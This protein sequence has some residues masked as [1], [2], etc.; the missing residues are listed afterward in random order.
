M[1]SLRFSTARAAT[2]FADFGTGLISSLL[3]PRRA[4]AVGK[5]RVVPRRD[6]FATAMCCGR[7]RSLRRQRNAAI[8][9]PT[10]TV[11]RCA[12]APP[13]LRRKLL[14]PFSDNEGRSAPVTRA[15]LPTLSRS[16]AR[17]IA[18][19]ADSLRTLS[20]VA[21]FAHLPTRGFERRLRRVCQPAVER[22]GFSQG[23]SLFT[24]R[25]RRVCQPAVERRGASLGTSSLFARG[26]FANPPRREEGVHRALV[27]PS[28]AAGLPTRRGE[29]RFFT[30]SFALHR[31]PTL[32][33]RSQPAVPSAPWRPVNRGWDSL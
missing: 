15:T 28:L 11:T 1:D 16:R 7:R 3:R 5:S 31:H 10:T 20:V 22:R 14:R 30:G 33:A 8:I 13:L 24:R 18:S 4:S 27:V 21:R 29:D 32:F 17:S 19:Y 26:G 12:R 6:G 9:L 2:P 25:L 23:R